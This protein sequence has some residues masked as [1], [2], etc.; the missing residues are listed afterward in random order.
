MGNT[1]KSLKEEYQEVK[2]ATE[3][4]QNLCWKINDKKREI[5]RKTQLIQI[6]SQISGLPEKLSEDAKREFITDGEFK[7]MARGLMGRARTR[8]LFLFSDVLV[9]TDDRYTYK[10][11]H[12][13]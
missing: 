3:S 6:Q 1:P 2:D 4:I 9:L 10:H 13:L 11:H 5:E 7:E 12:P 8:R